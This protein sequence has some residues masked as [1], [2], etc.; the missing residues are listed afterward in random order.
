MGKM[1]ITK[2]RVLRLMYDKAIKDENRNERIGGH[3][4]VAS[5]GDI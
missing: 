4:Q 1:S 3:L 5:I 2:M